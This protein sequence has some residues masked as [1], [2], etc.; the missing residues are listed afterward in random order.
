LETELNTISPVRLADR[1]DA[2]VMLIHGLDDTVVLP[3]QSERMARALSKAGKPV[4]LITLKGADHWL[5]REDV[6]IAMVKAS[7]EFVMKNN[8]PDPSPAS[9]PPAAA[10]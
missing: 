8:P 10:Q 9:A 5:L 7:V 1:A 4:E 6:R 2:P 3:E